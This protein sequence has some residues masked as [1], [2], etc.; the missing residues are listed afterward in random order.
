VEE[1]LDHLGRRGT[2]VTVENFYKGSKVHI[3]E[4]GL[5][6]DFESSR[7]EVVIESLEKY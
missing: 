6:W 1:G 4:I 5:L 7:M 2:I 3:R